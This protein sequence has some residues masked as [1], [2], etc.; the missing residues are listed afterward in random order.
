MSACSPAVQRA[1]RNALE[2]LE[3]IEATDPPWITAGTS[4]ASAFWLTLQELR[5]A[6][7][8]LEPKK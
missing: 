4:Q 2:F 7:N 6:V 5:D 1:L 3:E 8:T